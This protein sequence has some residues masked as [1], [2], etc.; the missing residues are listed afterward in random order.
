MSVEF[1]G[2][3]VQTE[4]APA[5]RA[6]ILELFTAH[7]FALTQDAPAADTLEEDAGDG[8]GVF[9]GAPVRG[10]PY[11]S[12]YVADWPDSGL[13]ARHLS[14]L[15]P[16]VELWCADGTLWGYT[17]F[18][19]GMVADRFASDPARMGDTADEQNLYIGDAQKFAEILRVS[20]PTNALNAAR[21][22]AGKFAGP[23]VDALCD[24]LGLPFAQGFTGIR[25][26]YG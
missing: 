1:I 4:D 8:V 15:A 3:H 10:N 5:V 20:P 16:V 22:H 24:A 7:G 9:V 19:G 13:L 12:V 25:Y 17:L 2:V 23:G 21:A 26:D 6:A 14:R 11:I 18:T